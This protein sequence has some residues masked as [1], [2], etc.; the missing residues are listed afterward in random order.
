MNPDSYRTSISSPLLH[1]H[2]YPTYFL[3]QHSGHEANVSAGRLS[4]L[5]KLQRKWGGRGGRS[6]KSPGR[7]IC[8]KTS[9]EESSGTRLCIESHAAKSTE[10]SYYI[11]FAAI[12]HRTKYASTREKRRNKKAATGKQQRTNDSAGKPDNG[13]GDSVHQVLSILR[14]IS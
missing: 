13:S 11:A 8:P 12:Q 14:K 4:L 2:P 7:W 9:A 3:S 10:L 6:L 1:A 5:P